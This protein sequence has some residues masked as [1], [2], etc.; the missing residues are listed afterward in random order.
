MI[1][2]FE[3]QPFYDFVEI[4]WG[5]QSVADLGIIEPGRAWRGRAGADPGPEPAA[6]VSSLESAVLGWPRGAHAGRGVGI[7]FPACIRPY[8]RVHPD[9][10]LASRC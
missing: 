6:P 9:D 5:A 7:L 8:E 1:F 10:D 2:G 3:R 4:D